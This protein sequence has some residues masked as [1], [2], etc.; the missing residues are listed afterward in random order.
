M[1]PPVLPLGPLPFLASASDPSRRSRPDPHRGSGP[2]YLGIREYRPGDSPRH[3]HWPSTARTGTVMVREL[4]EERSQ[5]LTIVV[6]TLA[7]VGDEGTPLDACCTAAASI[8]R[9]AFSEG[10]SMRII[11][12]RLGRSV[13]VSDDVDE[14]AH[15]RRL[16]AIVPDGVPLAG[17][18]D[19]C[20]DAFRDVDIVI[21]IFPTWRTNGDGALARAIEAM[22]AAHTSVVAVPV[23]VGPDDAR[24]IASLGPVEVD[25]LVSA[26]VRSGADVYPWRQG[27]PLDVALGREAAVT[28]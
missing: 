16:A 15:R 10:H 8:A 17:F 4:E 28:T 6:D 19:T 24:R 9:V 23:E 7:D 20:A 14:G 12:A 3:V 11:S 1:L 2:E 18:V 27:T 13:D 21:L 5:R 25:G 22:S 26:L